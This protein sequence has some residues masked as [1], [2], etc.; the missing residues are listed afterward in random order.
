MALL[1]TLNGMGK[2]ETIPWHV[3]GGRL[4]SIATGFKGFLQ[5]K[6]IKVVRFGGKIL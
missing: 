2:V 1:M 6:C 5:K 4:E 3:W